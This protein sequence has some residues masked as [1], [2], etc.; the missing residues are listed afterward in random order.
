M[1]KIF[2]VII[3]SFFAITTNAQSIDRVEAIIG[4]EIVLRSDIESQYSQYISQGNLKSE[5]VKCEMIEDILFQKLLVNQAKIDS[6]IVTDE[7]IDSEIEK[8]I[9]YFESQLGSVEKVE[10]YFGKS[11]VEIALELGEVIRD[12]FLAQKV[13]ASIST[14]I[15]VTPAEVKIFFKKQNNSDIPIVP[16]KVEVSQIIIKPS[17]TDKE[18][19][20][21][22]DKLNSFR[23]R[24]YNGENFEMLATLYSDDPGSA[25]KGGELGYVNRGDLVPEFERAAFRLK[26]GEISEVVESQFGFHIV[27]LIDRRGEQINVRHILLKNKVSSTSLYNAK[28]KIER[29]EKEI[30]DEIISFDDAIIKYSEDESKNNGG[31]LLNPN[32][33]S[34]MHIIDDMA[35]SLKYTVEKLKVNNISSVLVMQMPD[36]TKAYRI[37]KVNKKIESHKANMINDF[38]M[39]KDIAINFKK[40]EELMKW[41]QKKINTTYIKIN[42]SILNCKFKN[43]WL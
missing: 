28:L 5:K 32:T 26:E 34:T 1:K 37:L 10:E 19:E 39:I 9:N 36:E 3:F 13:Q 14:E 35:P 20:K 23:E 15:K 24:V 6:V 41:I 33:M 2:N 16:T 12:Q 25:S 42:D 8:R 27:Q 4:D 11:R 29:I 43:K 31:L 18:K 17:I 30:K 22:R 38:S 21:L 7:D 40:Q